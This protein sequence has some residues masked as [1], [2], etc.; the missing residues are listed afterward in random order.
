MWISFD[1]Y[2]ALSVDPPIDISEEILKDLNPTL[3]EVT[4]NQLQNR[5][6]ISDEQIPDINII[7][8]NN[9]SQIVDEPE[10]TEETPVIE[11][12]PTSTGELVAT[13]S[14]QEQ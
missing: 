8:N 11:E 6:Y 7:P 13:E 1:V 10:F 12:L 9:L 3:D 4:L 14:G 5:V 2:R